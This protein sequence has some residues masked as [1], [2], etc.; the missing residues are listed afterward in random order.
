[1][2]ALRIASLATLGFLTASAAAFA[3]APAPQP[4][5][6]APAMT[7]AQKLAL[8]KS[9]KSE[10]A[11]DKKAGQTKNLHYKTFIADCMKKGV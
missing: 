4:A 2:T 9:C 3:Q 7:H 6:P 11:T 1:M 10:W 8:E 5:T